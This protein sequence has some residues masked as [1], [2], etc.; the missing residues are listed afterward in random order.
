MSPTFVLR[1]ATPW[2]IYFRPTLNY[3]A[4]WELFWNFTWWFK[5][6][7]VP[8]PICEQRFDVHHVFQVFTNMQGGHPR[9]WLVTQRRGSRFV[10]ISGLISQTY[11]QNHR[12]EERLQLLNKLLQCVVFP[13]SPPGLLWGFHKTVY[14]FYVF[15]APRNSYATSSVIRFVSHCNHLMSLSMSLNLFFFMH[16]T[17][18]NLSYLGN[19]CDFCFANAFFHNSK[20]S[21]QSLEAWITDLFTGHCFNGFFTNIF[22][23]DIELLK[24]HFILFRDFLTDLLSFFS[25]SW[26]WKLLVL[27]KVFKARTK[28]SRCK[29]VIICT[30]I[31]CMCI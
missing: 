30:H 1:H 16:F 24:I 27:N 5:L 6:L 7:K 13:A 20:F 14:V 3:T 15:Q 29:C 9:P 31:Y 18:L 22:Y 4:L 11:L 19:L 8:V 26:F 12:F 21:G 17:V 2:S 25:L 28:L 23:V 10:L